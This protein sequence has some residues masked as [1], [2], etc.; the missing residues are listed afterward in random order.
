VKTKA[1]LLYGTERSFTLWVSPS[2]TYDSQKTI[3]YQ[4]FSFPSGINEIDVDFSFDPQ[5]FIVYAGFDTDFS[6]W[7]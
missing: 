7:L 6:V 5:Y 4:S 1:R 2:T 3:S